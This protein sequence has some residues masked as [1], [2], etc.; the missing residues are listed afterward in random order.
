MRHL[1]PYTWADG[2]SFDRSLGRRRPWWRSER[3]RW[4]MWEH[5]CLRH[6]ASEAIWREGQVHFG[7]WRYWSPERSSSY[8]NSCY[9]SARGSRTYIPRR[10]YRKLSHQRSPTLPLFLLFV[11]PAFAHSISLVSP[12]SISPLTIEPSLCIFSLPHR[13]HCMIPRE[14]IHPRATCSL[15]QWVMTIHHGCGLGSSRRS[16]TPSA[17]L[18]RGTLSLFEPCALSFGTPLLNLFW[19]DSTLQENSRSSWWKIAPC[20]RTKLPWKK[21]FWPSISP[22]LH[23]NQH[24]V[25]HPLSS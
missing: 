23:L 13:Y 3:I 11:P 12:I 9:C 5:W 6:T 21:A 20:F 15:R 17:R 7:L 25:S 18:P 22:I 14:A 10:T 8:I 19:R 16:G 2:F 4:Q 1:S 24:I